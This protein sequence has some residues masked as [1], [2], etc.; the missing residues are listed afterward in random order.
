MGTSW[1]LPANRDAP[2][3][4]SA[5]GSEAAL[6]RRLSWRF[7][8]GL[9][10]RERLLV[11]S[12]AQGAW[13]A[14]PN[15]A[16]QA[17]ITAEQSAATRP[18]RSARQRTHA[19]GRALSFG[20]EKNAS[21]NG[22]EVT[23]SASSGL[24]LVQVDPADRCSGRR[25]CFFHQRADTDAY[26]DKLT[27]TFPLPTTFPYLSRVRLSCESYEPSRTK[28]PSTKTCLEPST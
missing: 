16:E 24:S 2:F 25:R 12:F 18:P 21:T 20:Y 9:G 26:L 3:E 14:G 13:A 5:A 11:L 10:H 27:S 28:Y 19:G 22:Y 1:P 23:V 15:A 7:T 8:F 6:T 4:P 17:E